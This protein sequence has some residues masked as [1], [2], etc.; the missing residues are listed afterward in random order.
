MGAQW[1]RLCFAVTDLGLCVYSS[2]VFGLGIASL[3]YLLGG[4]LVLLAVL[5]PGIRAAAGLV[6]GFMA[7]FALLGLGLLLLAATVG[8]SFHLS[9]SNQIIASGLFALGVLGGWLALL[10]IRQLSQAARRG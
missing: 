1:L 6:A 7:L 10:E 8:G 4:G 2:Q 3:L 5:L 9:P